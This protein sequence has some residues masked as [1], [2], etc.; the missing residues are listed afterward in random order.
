MQRHFVDARRG[1]DGHD[2]ARFDIAE[3]GDL[4]ADVAFDGA[5]GAQADDVGLDAHPTQLADA[6][7]RGLGLELAAGAEVRQQGDVDVEHVV[8]AHIVPHLPDRF[9]EGL[10]FDIAHGA[11][12]FHERDLGVEP[13]RCLDD[14]PLDFVGD[15]R[16][17]LDGA[18]EVVAAPLFGDH[19]AVHLPGGDVVHLRQIFINE[20]LVMSQ[21]EV[22]FRSIF[23]D[24]NFAVLI[25]RH[26][27]WIHVEIG[28]ELL[29]GDAQPA[30]LEQP[31]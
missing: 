26:R 20:A 2:G 24:E 27:P 7:L 1:D 12:D 10:P 11:A 5:V 23:G 21:V 4:L 25:G 3:Q 15:V 17:Y 8:A 30:R 13:L 19:I 31:P 6:V 9:E 18:A 22:G 29:D 16:H 28:I 14:A